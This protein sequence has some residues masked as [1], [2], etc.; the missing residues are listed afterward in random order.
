MLGGITPEQ[1][2]LHSGD[3][4]VLGLNNELAGGAPAYARKNVVFNAP[5]GGSRALSADVDFD[6]PGGATVAYVGFWAAGPTF[7]GSDPVTNEVYAAQGI[8]RLLVAGT[9]LALTD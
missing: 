6:V 2:S 7:L 5:A 8:Y 9:T 1:A 4:G 3:P